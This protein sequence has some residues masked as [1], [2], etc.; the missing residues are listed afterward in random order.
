MKTK[1]FALAT[2]G[3][4]AAAIASV[5]LAANAQTAPTDY[6]YVGVGV[7][8]G[9]LGGN[10]SVGLA[11]NSK[12]RVADQV[13]VRPNVISDLNFGENGNTQLTL[14]VTYDFNSPVANGRLLPFA[15]AGVSYSTGREQVGPMVTA[16]ADYRINDRLTANGAVNVNFYRNTDVNGVVGLGY[17]F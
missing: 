15:G 4:A 12:L 6:N 17:N 11:V 5:P 2:A 10:S 3:F 9:E 8:V 14:P 13:S 7:G 16:G 1:L